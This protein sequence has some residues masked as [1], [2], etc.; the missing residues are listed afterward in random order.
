MHTRTRTRTRAHTQRYIHTCTQTETHIGA[1]ARKHARTHA[2]THADAVH[3]ECLLTAGERGLVR[4]RSTAHDVACA[5][6]TVQAQASSQGKDERAKAQ[7]ERDSQE[8]AQ[9]SDGIFAMAS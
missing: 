5:H 9:V 7:E 6:V 8:R 3:L 1:R 2:R 4:I